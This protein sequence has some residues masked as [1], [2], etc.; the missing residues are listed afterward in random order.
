MECWHHTYERAYHFYITLVGLLHKCFV[1][2][3]PSFEYHFSSLLLTFITG[4]CFE[5]QFPVLCLAFCLNQ[6]F[7]FYCDSSDW[8]PR[9]DG[10]VLDEGRKSWKRLQTV[11][12]IDICFFFLPFILR[13]CSSFADIF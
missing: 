9:D 2:F 10:S 12:Y 13:L 7:E 11:S 4:V 3:L 1:G 5:E 6:L 8:L